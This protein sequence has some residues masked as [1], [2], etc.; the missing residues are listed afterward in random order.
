MTESEHGLKLV[1]LKLVFAM[2]FWGA[3]FVSG[4][5][6]TQEFHPFNV[7]VIRFALASLF[8]L[9]YLYYKKPDFYKL[10]LSQFFK[11]L[12]LGATGVFAYNY[13]FFN[14]L[15][16]VEAGRSSIIIATNPAF[17]ALI[18][19][20]FLGE[21]FSKKKLLGFICA[22]SGALLVISDGSLSVLVKNPLGTG[23]AYL[24]GAVISWVT[25]TI[26]GKVF[27][28]KLTSLE[29]TTWACFLGCLMLIP[30][31]I[32][33]NLI[34][35]LSLVDGID[36][37]HF[38]NIGLLATCLGFIWF[39]DGVV[40]IGAATAASFINLVPLV[41]ITSGVIFLGEK[42]SISLV[43]G[44]MIVIVGVYLVNRKRP[45]ESKGKK[46]IIPL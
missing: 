4:R 35:E 22:F 13:F 3:A 28:K 20:V 33:N 38:A 21:S 26:L 23:E 30:F 31:G 46:L 6:L 2:I 16:V 45:S 40:K 19:I 12:S 18:A 1:Y 17:T 43:F 32:Q 37:L 11:V 39:Y 27:L 8:L 24:I 15:K 41:G 36:L 25:Y 34:S 42:V 5:V 29:A 14:G 9:P 10:T 7:G 44:S